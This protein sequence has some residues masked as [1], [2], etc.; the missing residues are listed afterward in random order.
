MH[1]FDTFSF[2]QDGVTLAQNSPSWRG[3]CQCLSCAIYASS[4]E[5]NR[6]T[7]FDLIF[8]EN[9]VQEIGIEWNGLKLIIVFWSG[10]WFLIFIGFL[11]YCR[12]LQLVGLAT[13]PWLVHRLATACERWSSSSRFPVSWSRTFCGPEMLDQSEFS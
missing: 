13:E 3:G 10:W 9:V 1:A 12:A 6:S 4:L 2:L 5:D 8:R 11:C 7:Y